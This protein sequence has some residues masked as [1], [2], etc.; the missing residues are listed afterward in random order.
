RK[1]SAA[2]GETVVLR[3]PVT[4]LTHRTGTS[5]RYPV[6]LAL[7]S[8]TGGHQSAASRLQSPRGRSALVE[9]T[10]NGGA[11]TSLRP[12]PRLTTGGGERGWKA[13]CAC[14]TRT[15]LSPRFSQTAF[16]TTQRIN[17]RP[18]VH[19]SRLPGPVTVASEGQ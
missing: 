11:R 17:S 18:T 16:S 10:Q 2:A 9:V 5:Y 13:E 4:S 19:L 8:L 1:D 15:R 6:R 14:Q 12:I 7:R 3:R